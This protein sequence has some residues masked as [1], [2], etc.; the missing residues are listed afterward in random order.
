MR[1]PEIASGAFDTGF[2]DANLARL[3]AAPH[4]PNQRAMRA[5]ARLLLM[6]PRAG[7]HSPLSPY[8][9]WAITDWFELVGER[10]L[11]VDIT[12]DGRR[13]RLHL[14]AGA[15]VESASD[16]EGSAEITLFEAESGVYA[17]AGGRQV[18]VA[19]VDPLAHA[20]GETDGSDGAICA[21]MNGRIAALHVADGDAV[22][23]GNR[24]AVVEAMKMEHALN[25]PFAG[26]VRDLVCNVG[27][28]VEM[29][30]RIMR[31]EERPA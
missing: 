31:V 10:R 6:R 30:E 20:A 15:S 17:L 19:L 12:V 26:I 11:G 9:P 5:S 18:F 13:E 24:L 1:T 3:G 8:D 21:P 16:G 14:A 2:I 25:A 29:G 7:M 27:E 23:A 4:A 28:Q 22:E